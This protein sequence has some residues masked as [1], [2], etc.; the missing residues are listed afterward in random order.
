MVFRWRDWLKSKH[1][2]LAMVPVGDLT[3]YA[4]MFING[5]IDVVSASGTRQTLLVGTTLITAGYNGYTC[6]ETPAIGFQTKMPTKP[7]PLFAEY[8]L[9]F[10][11]LYRISQD[12]K[13]FTH[14][15]LTLSHKPLTHLSEYL[16]R[17]YDKRIKTRA[18]W[19][20]KVK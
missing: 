10:N 12:K 19:L 1:F 16:T 11:K 6:R 17:A 3:A 8:K 15:V 18:C 5:T 7:L 14:P 2:N 9:W 20:T 4:R 13:V